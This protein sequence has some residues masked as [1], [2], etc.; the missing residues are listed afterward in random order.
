MA[1]WFGN[2][3]LIFT[4]IYT[5]LDL[6]NNML[7][8]LF[9][10]FL[11]LFCENFCIFFKRFNFLFVFINTISI[12]IY[13]ELWIFTLQN[14][15]CLFNNFFSIYCFILCFDFFWRIF[16]FIFFNTHKLCIYKKLFSFSFHIF[17]W[18]C[19]NLFLSLFHWTM[20]WFFN[21]FWDFLFHCKKLWY[22]L[23]VILW[24]LCSIE[25]FLDLFIQSRYVE[26]LENDKH[27]SLKI[28]L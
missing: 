7:N 26:F 20:W 2:F 5:G 15:F 3:G 19:I 28:F 22:N 25:V 4:Q 24:D 12:K 21:H 27:K 23:V 14:F 18:K 16:S 1:W 11:I 6:W 17:F 9:F 8:T 13:N 10:H